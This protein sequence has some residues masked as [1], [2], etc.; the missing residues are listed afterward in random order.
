[1]ILPTEGSS[2]RPD[3]AQ[4]ESLYPPTMTSTDLKAWMAANRLRFSV[5][6]D[7]LS[8]DDLRQ[9][10]ED[11]EEL[12]WI[13]H[14][15]ER[16][17]LSSSLLALSG[18]AES[19]IEDRARAERGGVN[20]YT[21]LTEVSLEFDATSNPEQNMDELGTLMAHVMALAERDTVEQE[22]SDYWFDVVRALAKE[23]DRLRR[24]GVVR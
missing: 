6:V 21:L 2:T 12:A 8:P 1:M 16:S 15:R 17:L 7:R 5:N 24:K 9:V 14:R 19:E 13:Y 23:R 10:A 4:S 3:A 18:A 11:A 22:V 20:E